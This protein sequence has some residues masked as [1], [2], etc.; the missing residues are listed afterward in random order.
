MV[1]MRLYDMYYMFIL[2]IICM[3]TQNMYRQFCELY[4]ERLDSW[5]S[6]VFY[7]EL[8]ALFVSD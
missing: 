3:C 4:L 6:R 2:F 5:I 8:F 1:Y 7:W